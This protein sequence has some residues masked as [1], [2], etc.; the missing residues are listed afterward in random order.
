MLI[1]DRP[2]RT[3]AEGR[4]R[5]LCAAALLLCLTM[6]LGGCGASQVAHGEGLPDETAA[7]AVPEPAAGP[8][9]A[10]G[11]QS[12]YGGGPASTSVSGLPN[13][14]HFD[15][16]E[17][18]LADPDCYAALDAMALGMSGER[19]YTIYADGDELVFHFVWQLPDQTDLAWMQGYVQA[20]MEKNYPA[21]FGTIEDLRAMADLQD[22]ALR[23]LIQDQNGA[24]IYNIRF[25]PDPGSGLLAELPDETAG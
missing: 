23:I 25:A 17:E 13:D 16:L 18:L 5:R 4:A 12:P 20:A 3:A 7:S 15:A 14:R 21:I 11:A 19:D 24:E 22:P 10:P 9:A 1:G 8:T 6:V 2:K